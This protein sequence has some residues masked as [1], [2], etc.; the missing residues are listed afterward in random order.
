[1]SFSFASTGV[2]VRA[3]Q[4]PKLS[5]H[6]LVGSLLACSTLSS[7]YSQTEPSSPST[8]ENMTVI[9][10]HH[11][12]N[13]SADTAS[14]FKDVAGFS[15]YATGGTASLPVLN[16]MADDRVASFVDGMRLSSECPN[17]MNPALSQIDPDAVATNTAIAG[18]TPVSM[19]GD[20]T[21][22]TISVERRA[23]QFAQKGSILVTGNGR[24]DWRSNGGAS[25]A[26]G[27]IT[28]ANDTVSLRYNASYSHAS[29]YSAGGRGGHV[30]STRYLNYNHAVTA[31]FRHK[32]HLF[33]VTFG[34]QDTPYEAFP[35]SYMDETNNRS[36][37][38]N[39]KYTGHFTWGELEARAFWKR[40]DHAMNMLSDKGGYSATRGMPMNTSGRTVGYAINATVA[41]TQRHSLKMGS[42]FEHN[43]LK[44]WWPPVMN[45]MMMGPGTFNNLNGAFRDHL[46]HFLQWNAQWTRRFSTEI[47]ARS[48][49][50]M[51]NTGPVTP[52]NWH[53][54]M[55]MA[56]ANAARAFN[57][58]R[59]GRTDNNVDV[60]AL[61]RWNPTDQL[62]LEGGYARKTRSPNLY[63]RY[64]WGQGG[65]SSKMIGW[66]G[67]GN[68]YVGSLNLRPEIANTASFTVHLHDQKQRIWD[69][70]VQPF[71]TYTQ[72]YI[73]V[74]RVKGLSR[75][76]NLLQFANHNA[77]SYGIN[78][79]AHSLLWNSHR[80]GTGHI[81]ATLSWVRGQDKVTR[82]SLYQQMP[83]NS[84]IS[85]H[86][87]RGPWSGHMDVTLVKAKSTVD[88]VRNEP[89]TPGYALLGLGAAYHWH[90]VRLDVSLDNLLNQRYFLPLSGRALSSFPSNGTLPS[91][92]LGVGRSV[93]LTLRES[94]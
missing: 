60:T 26:S 70:M 53:S 88:W 93:N 57:A 18:I 90:F 55:G 92:V 5:T 72:H 23:P 91:P 58:S 86:E 32:N 46:G 1:M 84:T 50:V 65:M 67:D 45:S 4:H 9:G 56:D 19:G 41:L 48:D 76:F 82:S 35:N 11:S 94:F 39:G 78:A 51:M 40:T 7:A 21:G 37:F 87:T 3:S 38:V 36:T 54:M 29:N 62:S 22:G 81:S 24:Q 25:G 14:L 42:S 33:S 85:L 34:Q 28:V 20:S 74:I 16:G 61:A 2:P 8:T 44:D 83:L 17:H 27:A 75:G 13:Q 66:F 63:E 77:Q 49:V 30:L 43:G 59:R 12:F 80:W 73:N 79:A 69:V 6:M 71:Y 15:S 64:S 47:G 89:K 31:G 68:G 10:N 52:Y